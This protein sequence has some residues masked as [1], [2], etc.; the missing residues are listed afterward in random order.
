MASNLEN[1]CNLIINVSEGKTGEYGA[2]VTWS[3]VDG[4][5][6]NVYINEKNFLGRGQKLSLNWDFGGITNYSISFQEPW[7]MGTELSLGIGLYD[8]SYKSKITSGGAENEY[9][10]NKK[11]GNISLGYNLFGD[12]NGLIRCKIENSIMELLGDNSTGSGIDK[13]RA[14]SLTFQ[15]DRDT[16]NHFFNP[17]SGAIDIFSIEYAGQLLGGDEDFTKY[18][19]DLR[20]FYPAFGENHAWSVRLKTGFSD[21]ELSLLEKYCLGGPTV[22]RGYK[23]NAFTGTE[24]LL[25]QLEYHVPIVEKIKGIIFVDVGN[26]WEGKEKIDLGDL[27]Y[28]YG[29]GLRINSPFGI[30]KLEYGFSEQ[31]TGE[32]QFG[33]GYPF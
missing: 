21:G 6:G 9:N 27:H 30:I 17:T 25:I 10:I 1:A 20:R 12:W 28:S 23:P 2:G 33:I 18:N 15:L 26:V 5:I 7:L 16:S 11:G 4:F 8:R 31:G 29:V 14:R 22:L 32:T 24:L 3:S 13:S 19:I